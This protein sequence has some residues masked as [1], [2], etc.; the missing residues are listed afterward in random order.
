M[1]LLC[2]YPAGGGSWQVVTK[3]GAWGAGSETQDIEPPPAPAASR[4]RICELPL[5]FTI[6]FYTEERYNLWFS[7]KLAIR[8]AMGPKRSI[9]VAA[10]GRLLL[11][12]FSN[13]ISSSF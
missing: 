12:H 7:P 5:G 9:F 3:P 13:S 11:W 4:K 1:E 8:P 10:H 6:Y 2:L